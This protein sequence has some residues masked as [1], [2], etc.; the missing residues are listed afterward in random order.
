MAAI[1]SMSSAS[2]QFYHNKVFYIKAKHSGK[3]LDLYNWSKANY[4]KIVQW[5]F[6]GGKNQQFRFKDAGGG[7]YYIQNVHSGKYLNVQSGSKNDEA[8]ILQFSFS[9]RAEFK[10]FVSSSGFGFVKIKAKHSGKYLSVDLASK[11][12]GAHMEQF[13]WL[14]VDNQKFVLEPVLTATKKNIANKV[15]FIQAKHSKKYLDVHRWSKENGAKVVQWDFHGGANQQFRFKNAGGGYYYIQNVN[16]GLYLR[17]HK[18]SKADNVLISQ[19]SFSKHALFQFQ[20]L[21]ESH[22][23][24]LIK[25]R[26]SGKY[27]SIDNA[28]HQNGAHLE[29]FRLMNVDNQRFQLTEV[30]KANVAFYYQPEEDGAL[31]YQP[32]A[33][34]DNGYK[35]EA[36]FSAIITVKNKDK[37]P[38]HWNKVT[39]SYKHKGRKM[40]HKTFKVDK[41]INGGKHYTWLNGRNDYH[42]LGDIITFSTPYPSEIDITYEFSGKQRVTETKKLRLYSNKTDGGRLSFPFKVQDFKVHEFVSGYSLHGDGGGPQVFALDLGVKEFRDGKMSKLRKGCSGDKNTDYL[43]YGKPIYSMSDGEIMHFF[44][45]IPENQRPCSDEEDCKL[46][47]INFAAYNTQCFDGGI[48]NGFVIKTEDEERI[49]YAHMIPGSLNPDLLQIGAKVKKGDFLGLVGNSG[50]SSAPHLHIDA[51]WENGCKQLEPRPMRLEGAAIFNED[52]L[53]A[54]LCD[55]K[56]IPWYHL[57]GQSLPT[58]KSVLRPLR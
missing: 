2:A 34:V 42:I 50:S 41:K 54:L 21:E 13:R 23:V 58:T 37:N 10:F 1:C 47:M 20:V 11:Q 48:G 7:Y 28:S 15:F 51:H 29:Q 53:R 57:H 30:K 46:A 9:K 25:A 40:T 4:G 18:A 43:C 27:L 14:N 26:N 16:S 6:H 49:A 19:W 45:N 39:F 52:A 24:F 36:S 38:L 35:I 22:G 33:N 8:R 5:G 17:M 44:S 56:P 32:F 31:I 12:N 3:Y 55:E